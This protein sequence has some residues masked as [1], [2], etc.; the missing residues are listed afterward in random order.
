MTMLLDGFRSILIDT[1][2]LWKEKKKCINF[3]RKINNIL[4]SPII[5]KRI[6]IDIVLLGRRAPRGRGLAES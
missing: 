4:H 1:I 3:G 5:H 6:I 2:V